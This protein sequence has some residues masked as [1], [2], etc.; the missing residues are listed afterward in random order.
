MKISVIGVG[1]MGSGFAEGLLKAGYEVIAYDSFKENAQALT[2]FGAKVAETAGEAIKNADGTIIVVPDANAI[3]SAL[4]DEGTKKELAGA[5]IMNASTTNPDEIIE[6]AREVEKHGGT[7]SEIS[8][9]IGADEL[10]ARQGLFLMGAEEKERDFWENV[11]SKIGQAHYVGKVGDA[12]KAESPMLFGS[13]FIS[14][15]VAYSCAMA[16]KLHVPEEVI[17]QQL[18]MFVPHAE[19]L[20]PAVM[21]RDY[22]QVNASVDRFK[23]VC[24]TAIRVTKSVN[25]PTRLLEDILILYKDTQDAGYGEQDG[26]AVVETLLNM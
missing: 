24:D 23:D 8:M 4:F 7:L 16:L 11:L 26:M 21:A 1:R 12:S 14:M 18:A 17:T 15:T 3:K 5:R 25:M 22:S 19:Y 13:I 2:K 9:L 10:R 6:I 20:V